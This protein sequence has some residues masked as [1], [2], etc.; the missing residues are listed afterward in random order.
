[1]P[2]FEYA[3]DLGYR[4]VET[5]VQVTADGVLVAFHD[6]DLARTCGVQRKISEMSWADV[7]AARVD[8][9]ASIPTLD[10]LLGTWPELRV[11]IDCK[12][13][14][15]VDALIASLLR[16][17]ALDRV[18]IG[19]FS[20]SRVHKLRQQLGPRLCTA[21]GPA[22]VVALRY[23]R[24]RKTA[25]NAAQVPV[26][27]GPLNV[28][29]SEFIARAAKLGLHVHVWTIDDAV[30]MNRLVDLGVDGVMTDR[31]VVLRE[32]FQQ[33]GLWVNAPLARG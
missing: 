29:T 25:A 15:A 33:R 11:N 23:G 30:E 17:N 28:V 22:G 5:D 14:A 13:N 9:T 26:R 7:S 1:M 31:P 16:C 20:D 2:A 4:Y 18:C 10:E 27:Q 8:G 19:A 24:M 6:N 12:S 21:L 32:V 3:V